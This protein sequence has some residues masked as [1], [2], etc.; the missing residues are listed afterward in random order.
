MP[1]AT[2]IGP[3][4]LEERIA[5]RSARCDTAA[6]ECRGARAQG[7]PDAGELCHSGGG[8]SRRGEPWRDETARPAS[9]VAALEQQGAATRGFAQNVQRA[10]EGRREVTGTTG[11]AGAFLSE[12]RAA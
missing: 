4:L 1:R 12:V 5:V 2:G 11:A 8:F 6:A 9:T 7:L 3:V 10:A